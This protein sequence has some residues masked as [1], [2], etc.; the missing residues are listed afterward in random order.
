[1]DQLGAD[2]GQPKYEKGGKNGSYYSFSS[3]QSD[4]DR[5][6]QHQIEKDHERSVTALFRYDDWTAYSVDEAP[7]YVRSND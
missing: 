1:M 5:L 4:G 7:S 2:L 3:D 6:I